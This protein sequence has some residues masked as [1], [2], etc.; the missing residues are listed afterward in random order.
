MLLAV[1]ACGPD[2]QHG[3]VK[4]SIDGINEADIIA[5]VEDAFPTVTA[6]P[7]QGEGGDVQLCV[8]S[9]HTK[10]GGFTYD[11]AIKEPTILTLL[12]PNFSTTSIV[13][14][15]GKTVK[16]KGDANR[17]GELE[18]DGNEDNNL[19]T[20]FRKHTVGK[21][22]MEVQREA[23]TFIRTHAST[24][25]AVVLFRDVFMSAETIESNPT[26]SLLAELKKAQ[27]KSVLVKRMAERVEPF[28]A[29][30]PGKTLPAFSATDIDGKSV[31]SSAY[32]GKNLLIVFC[33]QW[34]ASFYAVKR[35]ARE[36][37]ASLD[38]GQLTM[39]F[40]SF[41][42]NK[43]ALISATNIDPLPG[44]VIYD[45]KGLRSPLFNRLGVRYIPGSILVGKDGKIK[46]RDIPNDQWK[47]RI[48]S[49]L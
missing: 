24:M 6:T 26:E 19:L 36:L 40:V 5:Y 12:Y 39:L 29:T 45:G 38:D 14:E 7:Q 2:E 22:L 3:R 15:P 44:K 10:G 35:N 48:P 23:A 27:P 30:A 32:E 49:L 21:N 18:I 37:S 41:D 47:T 46:A 25:A 20:E 16:L 9:I 43:E 4:G 11:R 34:D 8:D 13:L 1:A 31:S 17:L 33:A 28:L 42:A